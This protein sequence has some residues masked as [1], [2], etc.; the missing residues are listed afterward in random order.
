MA[1]RVLAI[2]AYVPLLGWLTALISRKSLV[3]FH[4]R[5]SLLLV[6]IALLG[7]VAWVVLGWLLALIPYV[8]P[9]LAV[10]LFALLAAVYVL[11]IINWVLGIVAASKGSE[12]AVPLTARWL[13]PNHHKTAPQVY[14]S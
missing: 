14:D 13:A 3:R 10:A 7:F 2:L 6:G 9:I 11:V 12:Q 8:G 5:Q 4:V 1:E